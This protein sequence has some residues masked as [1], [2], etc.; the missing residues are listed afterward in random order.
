[1]T[2]SSKLA[3]IMVALYLLAIGTPAVL[4]GN[5]LYQRQSWADPGNGWHVDYFPATN[6]CAVGRW[7]DNG[8]N[9]QIIYHREDRSFTMM[10]LNDRWQSVKAETAFDVTIRMDG[11][12]DNWRGSAVTI[13]TN[14][15]KPGFYMAGLKLKFLQAF[16]LRNRID[17]YNATTGTRITALLLDGSNAAMQAEISC[18]DAHGGPNGGGGSTQPEFRS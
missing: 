2:T 1:M 3:T 5:G 4:A 17:I 13:W 8:V 16:M 7:H 14:D 12:A 10:L 9:L 6:S 11:G 18:L 15:G